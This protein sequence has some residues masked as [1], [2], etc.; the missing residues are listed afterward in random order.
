MTSRYPDPPDTARTRGS[1]DEPLAS[2]LDHAVAARDRKVLD[3][4]A[5]AV[6]HRE[7]ALAYQPVVTLREPQAIAFHEGLIR[8]FDPT[9]RII[10]ASDFIDVVEPTELGREIDCI[11]LEHG[12]ES[13]LQ[14]PDLRLSVNMSARSIGIRRWM[15][16]LEAGLAR[17]PTIADRLILEITERTAITVPELVADFME[18]M[19]MRGIAFALDDFGA[20]Y[21]SFR[22]FRNFFFDI[23]KIDGE[24]IHGIHANP[25]NQVL[26]SA[27]AS[28]A[29]HFDMF[30][31]AEHVEDERDAIWLAEHGIDC[32]QGHFFGVPTLYPPW[33][34]EN[35]PVKRRGDRA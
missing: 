25:D 5:E 15:Q 21:T 3:M 24:F 32:A 27:L 4:V 34:A 13:L 33:L 8:V 10:P 31:V 30:T 18:E 17:D 1:F 19:Q 11:S 14:V 2:P 9:G 12:L 16:V 20:G 28:I 6:A 22:H 29:G 26:T 7:T 35:G 23:V